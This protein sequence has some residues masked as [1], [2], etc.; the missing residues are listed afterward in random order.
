MDHNELI[1]CS[2]IPAVWSSVVIAET[3]FI[4]R[5]VNPV[6]SATV[7]NGSCDVFVIKAVDSC[8]VDSCTAESCTAEPSTAESCTVSIR[9]ATLSDPIY[10]YIIEN[11]VN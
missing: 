9:T 5:V 4:A 2:H 10:T 11:K 6:D 7:D 8:S 1:G 3:E